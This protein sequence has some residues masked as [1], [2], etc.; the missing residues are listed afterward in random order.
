[1]LAKGSFD[2]EKVAERLMLFSDISANEDPARIFEKGTH[3]DTS[4]PVQLW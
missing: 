4:S 1:M 2:S 3:P